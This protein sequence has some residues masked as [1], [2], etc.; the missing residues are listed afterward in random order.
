MGSA[1]GA[2]LDSAHGRAVD[3]PRT[4]KRLVKGEG[5]GNTYLE[6]VPLP[7]ITDRQV[8]IRTHTS[9]I[10][11]GS[12]ILG[13]YRRQDVVDPSRMGY[14]VAGT[15]AEAG[16][17][18]REAGYS[19]GDRVFVMAPHAEYVVGTIGDEARLLHVP[20]A[21]TWQ[22]IPFIALARGG[23][24]WAIASEANST[25][26]I[27]VLGQ[28][29]VGNLV[30]QAHRARGAGRLITV[31][32][33]DIRVRIS[34]DCGADVALHSGKVDPLAEVKRL[35]DGEGADVVV[36][37]VG[38]PP[39]VQSFQQAFE[40]VRPLGTVHLVA[41]NQ[42]P[43]T[44]VS[45]QIQRRKLIGGYYLSEPLGPLNVR[46]AELIASG[47]IRVDPM[48]THTFPWHRASE[49]FTLLDEHIDQALGVLLEW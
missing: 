12:E 1:T 23:V 47:G 15:V 43:L 46:A 20:E 26:T 31:D 45:R 11:R 30:M 16:R 22:Q 25:D 42:G 2:A 18:A 29:L 33:L 28:G 6:E 3:V 24:A 34:Q 4:M 17:G 19:P 39:G 41:M 8:L 32:P 9:L 38:G 14:S 27:V 35:T 48:I 36:D 40:M 37:C 49:A 21:L 7:A 44:L 13:R 5:Y 10:S